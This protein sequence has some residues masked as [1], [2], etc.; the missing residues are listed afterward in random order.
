MENHSSREIEQKQ[1]T[2][3]NVILTAVKE[4][5]SLKHSVHMCEVIITAETSVNGWDKWKKGNAY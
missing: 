1:Y 3:G 5:E 4:G 2:D